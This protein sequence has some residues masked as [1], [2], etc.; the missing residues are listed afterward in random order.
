LYDCSIPGMNHLSQ[1]EYVEKFSNVLK[2]LFLERGGWPDLKP[3]G[4][5]CDIELKGVNGGLMDMAW[6]EITMATSNDHEA[7]LDLIHNIF[8]SE[9]DPKRKGPWKP[10]ASLAYDNYDMTTLNLQDTVNIVSKFPSLTSR[11]K[12]VIAMSLWKT[13]GRINEWSMLERFEFK[14]K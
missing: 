11:S 8:Y 13:E 4:I 9:S 5:L 2:P 6:S 10:H 1:D 14:N 12:R 3:I 7:C